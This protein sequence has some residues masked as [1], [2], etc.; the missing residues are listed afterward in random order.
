[1]FSGR[2]SDN[3]GRVRARLRGCAEEWHRRSPKNAPPEIVDRINK[4]INAALAEHKF[5]VEL[6]DFGGQVLSGLPADFGRLI[7]RKVRN[8]AR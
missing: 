4:Q 8:G 2:P 3:S 7:G 5:K 1:M 6:A